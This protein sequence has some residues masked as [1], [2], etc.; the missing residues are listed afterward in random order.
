MGNPPLGPADLVRSEGITCDIIQA[1]FI[2]LAK[3][4][5]PKVGIDKIICHAELINIWFMLIVIFY[6]SSHFTAIFWKI[7]SVIT[8]SGISIN[9][10]EER[11]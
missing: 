7:Q 9:F 6:I 10:R 5:L 2:Y 1:N 3:S 11:L 4:S 8:E